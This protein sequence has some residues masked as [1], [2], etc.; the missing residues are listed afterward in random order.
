MQK[1]Y[2]YQSFVSDRWWL[3]SHYCHNIVNMVDILLLLYL[4]FVLTVIVFTTTCWWIKIYIKSIK[5]ANSAITVALFLVHT[6]TRWHCRTIKTALSDSHRKCLTVYVIVIENSTSVQLHCRTKIENSKLPLC[7]T[8]D[9]HSLRITIKAKFHYAIWSQTGPK[10][11]AD[12]S[13]LELYH[14]AR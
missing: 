14:L 5:A 11:V 6:H 13:E 3:L 10:L 12:C 9:V 4:C 2:Y 1:A 8:S 7:F